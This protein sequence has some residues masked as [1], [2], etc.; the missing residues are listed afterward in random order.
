MRIMTKSPHAFGRNAYV[1]AFLDGLKAQYAPP[2]LETVAHIL[3]ELASFVRE[4]LRTASATA[5]DAYAGAAFAHVA[6]DLWTETHSHFGYGSVV[7]RFVDLSSG[8]V[9]ELPLGVWR[10]SGRRNHTN[11]RSWVANRVSFFGLEMSDVA[12]A[13]TDSGA[14]VRKAMIGFTGAWVPCASHSIHKAVRHAMGG[15]GETPTQR[16]ARLSRSVSR[17]GRPRKAC[18]NTLGREFLARCRATIGFFEHSPVETLSLSRIAVPE[19]PA[20]RNLL[21]D[22]PTRWGS[23]FSSL[24]RLYAMWPRLF[25]F[26]RSRSLT[27]DQLKRQ[28]S[29]NDGNVTR[30]LIA[31]LQPAFGVTKASERPTATL[32][33]A[34]L[35]VVELRKT[36]H[37]ENINVPRFP[38]FPLAVGAVDI[39]DYLKHNEDA[40]MEVDNRLYPCGLAYIEEEEAMNCLGVEARTAVLELRDEIDRLFFNTTDSSKNW[41]KNS[42]VLG[43]VY[44]TPGGVRTMREVADWIGVENPVADAEKAFAVACAQLGSAAV[45]DSTPNGGGLSRSGQV[46]PSLP[47]VERT[48]ARTSLLRWES[49]SGTLA[50]TSLTAAVRSLG[51]DARAELAA[52]LR[53]T[54]SSQWELPLPFW[55]RHRQQFP[56]LYRLAGV[57][58]G[59]IGSSSSCE[60][61]FSFTGGL[62]S[63]ERSCLS[64][65][66]IEMHSLVSANMALVPGDCASVPILTHD[67]AAAFRNHMNSFVPEEDGG[68]TG[69]VGDGWGSDGGDSLVES[70]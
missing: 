52:F 54:E 24:C 8:E 38:D 28:I 7:L 2:A 50:A 62:V 64:V 26:F 47:S 27:A 12:S 70:D 53:M 63:D 49:T 60:R 44:L 6:T 18:R 57:F 66:S 46:P 58:F 1:R 10:C 39:E 32:S 4:A 31:V 34:F 36:M 20:C 22:V 15:S 45:V 67:A 14:N 17:Q 35:L 61:A 13:T 33:E 43:A 59:A 19:D 37:M 30:Q 5:K 56:A 29:E 11:I 16:S 48:Q 41:M 25:A 3:T 68:I 42:A 51:T 69:D 23:T 9:R 55:F 40:V 21:P 65:E